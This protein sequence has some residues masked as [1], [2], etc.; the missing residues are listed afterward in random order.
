MMIA[1]HIAQDTSPSNHTKTRIT[2]DVAVGLRPFTPSEPYSSG[3]GGGGV[4]G[5]SPIAQW[6]ICAR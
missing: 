2:R 6:G 3:R 5:F 1:V 4:E